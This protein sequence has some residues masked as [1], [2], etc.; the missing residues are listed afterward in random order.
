MRRRGAARGSAFLTVVAV[1]A[2]LSILMGTAMQILVS[3]LR[4]SKRR[5]DAAYAGELARSGLDWARACIAQ[6]G[7]ASCTRRLELGGGVVEVT[8][9]HEDEGF[10][11]TAT[12]TIVRGSL[13][14]PSR[15]ASTHVSPPAEGEGAGGTPP[16]TE[17]STEPGRRPD[18]GPSAP[19]DEKSAEETPRYF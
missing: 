19:A 13:Q 3:H 6:G 18:P 10:L 15:T 11:V 8:V 2:L 9:T 4:E 14:G 5:G 17:P 12:A 16:Y 1:L 7:G